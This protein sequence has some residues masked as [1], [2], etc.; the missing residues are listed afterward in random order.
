MTEH[1][2]LSRPD[3][4]LEYASAMLSLIE[5][6]LRWA[7][8]DSE[9]AQT[10]LAAARRSAQS[11]LSDLI[12]RADEASFELPDQ[13]VARI[14][15]LSS[16]EQQI[17]WLAA[18]PHLDPELRTHISHINNSVLQDY[19]D[20]AL[21]LKLLCDTRAERLRAQA[22][23]RSGG[24]LL[25]AGLLTLNPRDTGGANMMLYEAVPA[26]HLIS[27]FGGRR[28][29]SPS[30]SSVGRWIHP[31][32]T[33]DEIPLERDVRAALFPLLTGFL[34]RP[35][36]A[37]EWYADGGVDF[38]R[39]VGVLLFGPAG[40]GRTLS[41]KALAGT[42]GRDLILVN[43]RRLGEAN[44]NHAVQCL[45]ALCHEAELYGEL[46]VIRDAAELVAGGKPLAAV[47]AKRIAHHACV[48]VLCTDEEPVLDP[49]LESVVLL[50]QQFAPEQSKVSPTYLWQVN[51]PGECIIPADLDFEQAVGR[52]NL[53][54]AQIR[55]AAH[56]AYLLAPG[57]PS[58]GT[59]PSEDNAN[60]LLLD[61]AVLEGAARAQVNGSGVGGLA[62]VADSGLTMEDV[63]LPKETHE[64]VAQVL[65]AVRNRRKVLQGW[66]LA[67]RIHRG[68]GLCCL[69]DG[70]PG[71][72]K[73]LSAEVIAHEL[74]LTLL[75]VNIAG[76]VDKYIGET[77]KNLT[78]IFS[79]ARPDIHL[80]L[81]DEADSLFAKRTEV[82]RST[83][84][85]S[86]MDVNVLLQLVERYEGVTILTTNLKR[87]IDSAFERRFAFKVNFPMP[88]ASER[89][90][91]W[92]HLLPSSVPTAEPVDY[93]YL[94]KIELAGGEIKNAIMR[95]AYSAAHEDK[96][97]DLDHLIEAA[98][99]EAAAAGRLV[100]G[101]HE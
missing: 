88:D 27:F 60:A 3:L 65:S 44:R 75:R 22:S 84:R 12:A 71:T 55:K 62:E 93:T 50:R 8:A 35:R 57:Q 66:G 6:K 46:V 89:E 61:T 76:I 41:L 86:N 32:V 81:F 56:M 5:L 80:L 48:V 100:R 18:A 99:R 97:I 70:D 29:L 1:F 2:C 83:D 101:D 4:A 78:R 73:T 43:G 87:G 34:E 10:E 94:S 82:S 21:C 85:Y 19:V 68:T 36:P 98:R 51:M 24:T 79:R 23:L 26:G 74:Q 95:A 9:P 49:S 69:F 15:G 63:I 11:L 92:R 39:G 64:Q 45:A 17:L 20:G 52:V 96:L 58:E 16:I 59:D 7:L 72:G 33:V 30:L 77:E 47:L 38:P 31:A 37:G 67:N 90:R 13:R 25:A 14:Y 40:S 91:I 53:T 28:A 54:P 42:L